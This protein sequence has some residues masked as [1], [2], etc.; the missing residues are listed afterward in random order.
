MT[1]AAGALLLAPAGVAA[2]PRERVYVTIN[3]AAQL[4]RHPFTDRFTFDVNREEGSTDTRYP[5]DGGPA[6]DAGLAV[7]LW[8]GLAAGVSVTSFMR[9]VDAAISARLP[10]PFFLNRHRELE[11]TARASRTE[12]GVH[13][14]ALYRLPLARALT[15]TVSGGPSFVRVEQDVV[16]P[17][18]DPALVAGVRYD[19]A[20]PYDTVAFRS[21]NVLQVSGSASGFHA[22]ADVAWMFNRHVGVGGVVR[23]TAVSV[24]LDLPPNGSRRKSVDAGGSLAGGG[25]RLAF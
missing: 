5:I 12:R 21:A 15:L 4:T 24:D 20:F 18:A 7:R 6:V 14:Q 2:Q 23:Y 17:G 16:A 8:R 3:G 10:H 22:G 19:E 25:L 1:L 13:V 9:D 11:G